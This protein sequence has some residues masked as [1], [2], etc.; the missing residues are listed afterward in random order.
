[1]AKAENFAKTC[2]GF[3]PLPLDPN[4]QAFCAEAVGRLCGCG[5]ASGGVACQEMTTN[6]CI[7]KS[8]AQNPC[9]PLLE[10]LMTCMRALPICSNE[11]VAE[12][13]Q[14]ESAAFRSCR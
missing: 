12:T 1:M 11:T 4:E 14:E 3:A 2:E 13:C 6:R 5:V 9:R 10:N 8:W 7:S